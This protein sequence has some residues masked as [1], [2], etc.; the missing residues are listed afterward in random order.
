MTHPTRPRAIRILAVS[1]TER[2]FTLCLLQNE[3]SD[4]HSLREIF[5][6]NVESGIHENF[7]EVGQKIGYLHFFMQPVPTLRE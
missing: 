3:C 5:P 1:S 6:S 4:H 7:P 2:A